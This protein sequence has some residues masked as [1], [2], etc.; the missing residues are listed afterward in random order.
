MQILTGAWPSDNYGWYQGQFFDQVEKVYAQKGIASLKEV[1]AAF[2]PG[3]ERF[4]L[5]NPVTL[6]RLDKI[7]PGFTAWAHS[8]EVRL[9]QIKH[10]TG[11]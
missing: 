10:L 8:L 6:R 3:S 1:R 11:R 7:S 5:G 4:A 9:C 2:P